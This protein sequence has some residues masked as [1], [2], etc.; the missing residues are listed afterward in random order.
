MKVARLV[1]CV[2]QRQYDSRHRQ[3]EEGKKELIS[4][5]KTPP[6]SPPTTAENGKN[7]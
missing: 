4:A 5:H 3:K 1:G 2:Y 6:P 7:M